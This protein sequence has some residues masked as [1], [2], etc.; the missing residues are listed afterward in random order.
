MSVYLNL[1][2]NSS[3]LIRRDNSNS[4]GIHIDHFVALASPTVGGPNG[5]SKHRLHEHC[6]AAAAF[7][8]PKPQ[9]A[10]QANHS[11]HNPSRNLLVLDL[12]MQCINSPSDR[13]VAW[14][15][16]ASGLVW[17][18]TLQ[19]AARAQEKHGGRR[20]GPGRMPGTNTR[21]RIWCYQRVRVSPYYQF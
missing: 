8:K 12:S 6:M 18:D 10:S 13:Q 2:W 19:H 11:T 9:L 5:R 7:A 20:H 21:E 1:F 4:V 3:V 17:W 16:L 14:V 15:A